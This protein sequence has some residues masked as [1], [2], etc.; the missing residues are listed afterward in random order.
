MRQG[1]EQISWQLDQIGNIDASVPPVPLI[2]LF[3][4]KVRT[5]LCLDYLTG[6]DLFDEM[7]GRGDRP[8][9]PRTPFPVDNGDSFPQKRELFLDVGHLRFF[10][11]YYRTAWDVRQ[12]DL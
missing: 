1:M 4:F 2:E 10:F 12:V 6:H 8:V 7:A 9:R 11:A 3:C 5:V